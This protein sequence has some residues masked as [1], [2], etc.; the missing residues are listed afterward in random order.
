[1]EPDEGPGSLRKRAQ[2]D[3][4]HQVERATADCPVGI[5]GVENDITVLQTRRRNRRLEVEHF[6]SDDNLREVRGG[7]YA[8]RTGFARFPRAV[9]DHMAVT[10]SCGGRRYR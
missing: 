7:D 6:G 8:E 1:M 4:G 5:P 2:G 3:P 9:L 10:A